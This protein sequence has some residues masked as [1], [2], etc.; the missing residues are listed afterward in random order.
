MLAGFEFVTKDPASV[1]VSTAGLLSFGENSAITHVKAAG[2][3]R[4]S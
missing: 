3:R 1:D 2:S 4:I